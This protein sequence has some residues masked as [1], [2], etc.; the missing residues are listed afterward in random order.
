MPISVDIKT[1]TTV[2]F[3]N[4]DAVR[5]EIHC[6]GHANFPLLSVDAGE[7]AQYVFSLPGRYEISENGI[8]DMKVRAHTE[9]I[10]I[11]RSHA[12]SS[13]L[14]QCVV[15]A[16]EIDRENIPRRNYF[17]TSK[18]KKLMEEQLGGGKSSFISEP[19]EHSVLGT[20]NSISV[21]D[22]QPVGIRQIDEYRTKRSSSNGSYGRTFKPDL[23]PQSQGDSSDTDSGEEGNMAQQRSRVKA[24]TIKYNKTAASST[25]AK[26]DMRHSQVSVKE[27]VTSGAIPSAAKNTA[28]PT[29]GSTSLP[30]SSSSSAA[31]PPRTANRHAAPLAHAPSLRTKLVLIEDYAFSVT[32]MAVVVGQWIEFRLAED[33]PAH[34]EHEICGISTIKQLCFESPLLQVHFHHKNNIEYSICCCLNSF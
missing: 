14:S 12:S 9:F 31:T 32:T 24:S 19:W 25:Q 20:E 15:E 18:E 23:A 13:C 27:S 26:E 17:P 21:Q 5:H 33:V 30:T 7:F 10:H 1:G 8:G 11:C 6:K 3:I 22:G 4:T 29:P 34:A 16:T 28:F 2:V